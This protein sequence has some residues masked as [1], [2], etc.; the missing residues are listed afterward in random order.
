MIFICCT[1]IKDGEFSVSDIW[2]TLAFIPVIGLIAALMLPIQ[3]KFGAEKSRIAIFVIG[4]GAWAAVTLLMNN[5]PEDYHL[6]ALFSNLDKNVVTVSLIVI[7]ILAIA[8]SYIISLHIME[9]K[10]Y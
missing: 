5:L 2:D 3:L 6:P 9:K 8:V 10:E 7:C 4:G 1:L